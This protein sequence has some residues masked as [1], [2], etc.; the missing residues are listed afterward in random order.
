MTIGL[1]QIAEDDN[2][3]LGLRLIEACFLDL[4]DDLQ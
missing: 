2:R 3:C 4:P 1:P